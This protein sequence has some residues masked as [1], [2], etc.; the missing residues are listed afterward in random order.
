MKE[1]SCKRGQHCFRDAKGALN[2]SEAG[3]RAFRPLPHSPPAGRR[4][5]QDKEPL[6][7]PRTYS[8]VLPQPPSPTQEAAKLADLAGV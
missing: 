3:G 4:A 2:V 5:T 1:N 7:N 8:Q 6:W